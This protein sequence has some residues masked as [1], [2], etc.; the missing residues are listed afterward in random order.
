MRRKGRWREE[1][2][3]RRRRRGRSRDGG[4]EG[5]R[6]RDIYVRKGRGEK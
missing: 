4:E 5:R 3:E 6:G 2:G 1:L